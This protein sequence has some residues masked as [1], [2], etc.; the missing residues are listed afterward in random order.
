VQRELLQAGRTKR[1]IAPP[2]RAAGA[3]GLVAVPVCTFLIVAGASSA[4]SL[5]VPA[6]RG[7][8]PEW[9]TGPLR[10]LGVGID[11]GHFQLL[12]LI[13]AGSYLIVLTAARALPGRAIAAS[14][15]LAHAILLVGPPLISQDVF[16]YLAFARMGTL[17]GLDP[18]TQFPIQAAPDAILHFIGWP[19][20]H[21]PYGPL[22]T[23][24]TYALAPLGLAGGF[25][26]LK[27]IACM[28]SL[29]AVALTARAAKRLGLSPRTAA[30]FLGL[31]PVLL[32]LAVGGAH[33][34][35]LTI[36]LLAAALALS[37][38][39]DRARARR[40][41]G[42]DRAQDGREPTAR[43]PGYPRAAGALA[44]AVGVKA[45]AGLVL[46][47]LVLGPRERSER[48][49]TLLS[50]CAWLALVVVVGLI[51]FGSHALGFL[52]ALHGQQELVAVH[53]IPAESARLFGLTGTPTWWREVFVWIF[54]AVLLYALW[55]TARGADWRTAAGWATLALAL[56]TAWLLPWYAIWALPLAA[57][58]RD[59]R[60]RVAALVFCAYA[61]AIHLELANSLL[62]APHHR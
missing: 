9:M 50:A 5:Y 31:N 59:R 36:L 48:V 44:L 25:W 47:F 21:S 46:P 55:R 11:P 52:S 58:S 56:C 34:D 24:G 30:V 53:S 38:G 4:P 60:L 27:A 14:I 6:R 33:N 10:G 1:N 29:G 18:Y 37:A 7:G 40:A 35:T 51:G 12:V 2:L 28:A 39:A 23:L 3:L 8:W 41:K 43:H 62:S 57:L 19:R 13:A 32:I 26:A 49:R 17:H 54:L 15:V 22:F 16:G 45:S 20:Q 42:V 61:L